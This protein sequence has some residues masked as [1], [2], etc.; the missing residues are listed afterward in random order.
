MK[1]TGVNQ[2]YPGLLGFA[3]NN[4]GFMLHEG[5]R[6]HRGHSRPHV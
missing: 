1:H 3:E 2:D 6:E 4:Y 5:E